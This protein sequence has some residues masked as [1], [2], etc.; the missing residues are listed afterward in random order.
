MNRRNQSVEQ[1]VSQMA[2][3]LVKYL[4]P[5]KVDEL[6]QLW[7][8]QP[9]VSVKMLQQ[10]I[11]DT[12]KRYP[13]L[14]PYKSEIRQGFW[15]A[16]YIV[17]NNPATTVTE[18][19]PIRPLTSAQSSNSTQVNAFYSVMEK[20]KQ[21]LSAPYD[22]NL[23]INLHQNVINERTFK[24]HAIDVR[25]FLYDERPNVPDEVFILNNLVQL[26]YVCLCDVVGA[27]AADEVMYRSAERA[28]QHFPQKLV[29]NLF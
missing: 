28:K 14:K 23:F 29:E 1:V 12:I 8:L 10:S 4:D 24:G 25:G 9:A 11:L 6:T 20:I 19:G 21:Q 15:A 5:A 13:Q 2:D 27:V 17:P 22:R 16:L 7:L 26:T 3:V 18:Q